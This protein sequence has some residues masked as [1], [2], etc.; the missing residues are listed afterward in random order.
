MVEILIALLAFSAGAALGAGY[1]TLSRPAQIS[2]ALLE[3]YRENMR[4][5]GQAVE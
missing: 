4:L 5:M 2:P 1:V 3:H